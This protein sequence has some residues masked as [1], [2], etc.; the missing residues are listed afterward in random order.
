M[1]RGEEAPQPAKVGR[2]VSDHGID[3]GEFFGGELGRG[4]RLRRNEMAPDV[5]LPQA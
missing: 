4:A 2:R 3:D 5:D 1:D